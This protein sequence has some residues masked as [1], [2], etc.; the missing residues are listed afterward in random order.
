MKLPLFFD[1]FD[2]YPTTI[3]T[4]SPVYKCQCEDY[5]KRDTATCN[6]CSTTPNHAYIDMNTGEIVV[7]TR[8]SA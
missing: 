3:D 2:G 4:G 5:F 7:Y 6:D 8:P 1:A